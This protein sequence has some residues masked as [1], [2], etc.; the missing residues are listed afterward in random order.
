V[1]TRTEMT[2]HATARSAA[3]IIASR[4]VMATDD[5]DVRQTTV[6]ARTNRT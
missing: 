3:V 5:T 4:L 2:K 1:T 6:I